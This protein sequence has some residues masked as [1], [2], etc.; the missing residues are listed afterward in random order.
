MSGN[1]SSDDFPDI[2]WNEELEIGWWDEFVGPD[3]IIDTNKYF[4]VC[5]N[6][7]G[8]CYG[9]TGPNSIDKKTGEM[10]TGSIEREAGILGFQ[11]PKNINK[12]LP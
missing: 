10:G 3:K 6:Y 1:F 8:G 4:V 12:N 7:L 9:S 2:P 5:A 11:K